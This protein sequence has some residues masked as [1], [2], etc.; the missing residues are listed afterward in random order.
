MKEGGKKLSRKGRIS[1]AQKV[2]LQH[3]TV[4]TGVLKSGLERALGYLQVIV[5]R[6]A[7][8]AAA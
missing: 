1:I 2:G 3:D 8:L 5:K 6:T 7:G 4:H